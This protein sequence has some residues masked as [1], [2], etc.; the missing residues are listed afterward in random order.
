MWNHYLLDT[1]PCDDR[2]TIIENI[3]EV[4]GV[5]G[6]DVS[7]S[8]LKAAIDA[9]C[10][11]PICVTYELLHEILQEILKTKKIVNDNFEITTRKVSEEYALSQISKGGTKDGNNE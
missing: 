6:A 2:K 3:S 5:T 10:N 11:E 7:T 8:V 4:E 1:I 9:V